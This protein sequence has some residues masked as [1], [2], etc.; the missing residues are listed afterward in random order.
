MSYQGNIP[1]SNFESPK[2]DRFTGI[3]GT[4][5]SLTYAVS[6]VADIIVWVNSVKQDFTN[7][8]VSGNTLTLGGTLVSAD[9]VEVTYVGRTYQSV[10]PSASSV[11]TNQLADDAVTAAKLSSTAV[12]NTNTNST[13]ITAQTEKSTLVDAD[14]FLLSDSAASGA[15]KYVQKSNL[16]S[17]THVRVGGSSGSGDVADITYDNILSNDYYAYRIIGMMETTADAYM[18]ILLRIG[19]SGSNGN[20]SGQYRQT[21]NG[22]AS[23]ST[24]SYL[25]NAGDWGSNSIK[26]MSASR[27]NDGDDDHGVFFD[28]I[29]YTRYL[30]K[31]YWRINS[32][33]LNNDKSRIYGYENV[34]WQSA[35]GAITGFNFYFNTGSIDNHRIDIYGVQSG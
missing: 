17:G 2:K 3:S 27:T 11:G 24:D 29:L 22:W 7:Y 8:S 35:T 30:N 12:D 14:K 33:M 32:Q 1:A 26:P 18:E 13:L 16:P 9:I 6:S 21:W 15:L 19:S 4:T 23:S 25:V 20:A 28:M 5:C 34:G 31:T 10:N